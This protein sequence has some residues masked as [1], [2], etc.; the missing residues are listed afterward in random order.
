MMRIYLTAAS[1]IYFGFGPAFAATADLF[2]CTLRF[3]ATDQSKSFVIEQSHLVP[4]QSFDYGH[5]R[6]YNPRVTQSEIPVRL[7]LFGN[8]YSA[9]FVYRQ[10][11]NI[12]A[13]G[14][15]TDASQWICDST[16]A[17]IDGQTFE[18]A[19]GDSDQRTNPFNDPSDRWKDAPIER[20]T[21]KWPAQSL[22][23]TVLST[24]HGS[25]GFACAFQET[26]Y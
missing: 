5:I 2:D 7:E 25:L 4:R 26:F 10:A 16:R 1:F 22:L 13:V 23:A 24:P 12:G 19:C 17:V 20:D 3:N 11:L 8:E 14:L 9:K 21:V 18:Q 6:G 15:P